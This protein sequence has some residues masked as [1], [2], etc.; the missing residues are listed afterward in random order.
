[1]QFNVKAVA[2]GS[3]LAMG[4]LGNSH[5][6]LEDVAVMRAIPGLTVVS[7]ADCTEIVKVVQ[8]VAEHKGPMYIRLTGGVNNP[9]VYKEDYEY[10]IGKAITLRDGGDL[11]LVCSGA[12]VFQSLQAAAVLAESNIQAEVVNMHTIK[13]LDSEKIEALV[14]SGKPILSV[15]EHTAIGGLGSAIAEFVTS[16]N[17]KVPHKIIGLEDKFG[18]TATYE[19]LLKLHGLD[20]NGIAKSARTFLSNL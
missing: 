14:N 9:I 12:M 18:K 6:G 15:E 20:G 4:F 3:G 17:K 2:L 13:P 11:V 7:P 5:Y 10:K 16:L 8:A 19:H 1:M